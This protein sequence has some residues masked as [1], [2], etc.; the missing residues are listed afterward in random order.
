MV[1]VDM[2]PS[3]ICAR[4]NLICVHIAPRLA[5]TFDEILESYAWHRLLQE[6]PYPIRFS[7]LATDMHEPLYA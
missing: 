7:Y 6:A 2:Q 3:E 5:G 1:Y 4:A